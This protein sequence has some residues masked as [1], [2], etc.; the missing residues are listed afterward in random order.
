MSSKI[1]IKKTN[2][3]FVTEFDTHEYIIN[4]VDFW[5]M[6]T[7]RRILLSEMNGFGFNID[8]INVIKNSSKLSNDHFKHLISMLPVAIDTY[9]YPNLNMNC[10]VKNTSD[11]FMDITTKDMIFYNGQEQIDEQYSEGYIINILAPN[12]EVIFKV[13]IDYNLSGSNATY[14]ICHS[15]Y[16]ELKETQY[17]L[18]IESYCYKNTDD[19]LKDA[20]TIIINK[21]TQFNESFDSHLKEQKN[22]NIKIILDNETDTLGN[23]ISSYLQNDSD[24]L[25]SSYKK[26][27]PLQNEIEIYISF[28]ENVNIKK[29]M[30]TNMEKLIGLFN[31][32]IKQL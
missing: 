6:N 27:H 24:I 18:T 22:N 17:K 14:N 28:K 31:N 2:Q 20:C 16:E 11:V 23:L 25:L 1:T 8:N 15:Y 29:C 21:I 9:K 32:I 10:S 26:Q 12:E 3:K 30:N 5:F 4:N 19:L 7:I 13:D